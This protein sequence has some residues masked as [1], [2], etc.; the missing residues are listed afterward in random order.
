MFPHQ[1][2]RLFPS[3]ALYVHDGY[4][5]RAALAGHFDGSGPA[6][7]LAGACYQANSIGLQRMP[8]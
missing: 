3:L 6:H 7:G 5:G 8:A 2:S 4:R 1:G